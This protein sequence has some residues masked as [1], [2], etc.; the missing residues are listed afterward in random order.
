[1][2]ILRHFPPRRWWVS[3]L[4][5]PHSPYGLVLSEKGVRDEHH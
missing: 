1:M 3:A 2:C 5:A 4:P